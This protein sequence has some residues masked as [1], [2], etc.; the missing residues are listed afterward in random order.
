V[1]LQ[2][3]GEHNTDLG[4]RVIMHFKTDPLLAIL[5]EN[6]F[7]NSTFGNTEHYRE[8]KN[9]GNE[10]EKKRSSIG[11]YVRKHKIGP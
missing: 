3:D 2:V 11:I 9:P 1:L 5:L 10:K 4:F 8:K 6:S 7:G